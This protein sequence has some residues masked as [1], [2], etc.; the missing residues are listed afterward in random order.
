VTYAHAR[1]VD[2]DVDMSGGC[3]QRTD[4][5]YAPVPTLSSE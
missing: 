5:S 3:E 1:D 2:V 4:W